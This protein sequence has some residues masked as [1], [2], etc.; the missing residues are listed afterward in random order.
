MFSNKTFSKGPK[1]DNRIYLMQEVKAGYFLKLIAQ[2][3]WNQN[4]SLK[5]ILVNTF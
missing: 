1:S 3:R 2:E 5:K 4:F